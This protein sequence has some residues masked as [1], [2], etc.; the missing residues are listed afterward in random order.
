VEDVIYSIA[1]SFH[2][3]NVIEIG[4]MEIDLADEASQ[5]LQAAG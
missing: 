1:S 2:G 3:I 5:V 4:F